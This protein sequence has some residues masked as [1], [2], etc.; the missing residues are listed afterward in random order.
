VRERIERV[1]APKS[2]P[3]FSPRWSDAHLG[4]SESQDPARR[5]RRK[6]REAE[7]HRSG[8]HVD[9]L[10]ALHE[11]FQPLPSLPEEGLEGE[12]P[13]RWIG[14]DEEAAAGAKPSPPWG[15]EQ[16]VHAGRCARLGRRTGQDQ[17]PP[18][19]DRIQ[20]PCS[21]SEFVER[22]STAVHN[23]GEGG[24]RVLRREMERSVDLVRGESLPELVE[25][26]RRP[27]GPKSGAGLI[28]PGLPEFLVRRLELATGQ[29]HS[30]RVATAPARGCQETAS[31][32]AEPL[33][34]PKHGL[35]A[36]GTHALIPDAGE[37]LCER[38]RTTGLHQ[39]EGGF[40]HGQ[41]IGTR[42]PSQGGHEPQRLV[43]HL[44]MV[45]TQRQHRGL[46][47]ARIQ[48]EPQAEQPPEADKSGFRLRL[49]GEEPGFQLQ[50]RAERAIQREVLG[51][52]D[53][54]R[55]MSARFLAQSA[56][57]ED[58]RERHASVDEQRRRP[59]GHEVAEGI[60]QARLGLLESTESGQGSPPACQGVSRGLHDSRTASLLFGRGVGQ[61][62]LVKALLLEVDI[63]ERGEE[64]D[65]MMVRVRIRH[66]LEGSLE[67]PCSGAQVAEPL[68]G[69]GQVPEKA[70]VRRQTGN[71]LGGLEVAQTFP[72]S[73]L[74]HL[75]PAEECQRAPLALAILLGAGEVYGPL[76][77]LGSLA[78]GADFAQHVG[79]THQQAFPVAAGFAKDAPRQ[80]GLGPGLRQI[81]FSGEREGDA[82]AGLGHPQIGSGAFPHG[83]GIRE[84]R[85]SRLGFAPS[86]P[87]LP[88][89]APC[90]GLEGTCAE[91]A[92]ASGHALEGRNL[93]VEIPKLHVGPGFQVPEPDGSEAPVGGIQLDLHT[94]HS[95]EHAARIAP[96]LGH[97]G[98]DHG[99]VE[100]ALAGTGLGIPSS[101][102]AKGFR[103]GLIARDLPRQVGHRLQRILG[104]SRRASS[105]PAT[106]LRGPPQGIGE[107]EPVDPRAVELPSDRVLTRERRLSEA[108]GDSVEMDEL[109]RTGIRGRLG[110]RCED[111]H[112]RPEEPR[113]DRADSRRHGRSLS[114]QEG[115][116]GLISSPPMHGDL[117]NGLEV[118]AAPG[119]FEPCVE[120]RL[121]AEV[122]VAL[123]VP[124]LLSYEVP[125]ALARTIEPGM[126]VR[127]PVGSRVATAFVVSVAERAVDPASLRPIQAVADASPLLSPR[128]LE[129]GIWMARRY[130]C[131][132]GEALEAVVPAAVRQGRSA[133]ETQLVELVDRARAECALQTLE[134]RGEGAARQRVLRLLLE[135]SGEPWLQAE[136]RRAARVS[137]SPLRTLARQGLLRMRR[138]AAESDPFRD[139]M[140]DRRP[141]P[142][143]L[144]EQEAA[145]AALAPQVQAGGFHAALLLGV[146]G[147]GKTEVYLR[148][149]EIVLAAGR[150]AILLVPEIA[151]TPQ[152][153]E[154]LLGRIPRVAVLHSGL[155]EGERARRWHELRS[156]EVRVAVGP[157]S[158]LFAPVAGLGLIILDEEHETTFKQQQSPRYHA[159]DVALERARLEGAVLVLGTATPSLEAQALVVSGRLVCHR[160][161]RRTNGRPMPEVA[162]VDMRH[163]KPVGAAAFFSAPLLSAME[164]TLAAGEQV[165]LFLNRRGFSTTVLC[166]LCG[167]S[168]A[169]PRCAIQ[170]TH[171][172]ST[173]R[174]L[175]HYCAHEIGAPACCPECRHPGLRYGGF[176]TERVAEAAARL[177][178]SHRVGRMDAESLRR[179]GAAARSYRAV[180]E[181]RVDIVVG[182]QVLAK[183]I[184]IP[185]ITL[186]G[187][188]SA[189]TSLLIPDFRSAER[190]F[191]LLCQ[192]AGRAGRSDRPGRVVVQTCQ[193]G[194]YAIRAAARHDVEGFW[195]E[196]SAHRRAQGYPPF[197]HLVRIVVQSP[198]AKV[199]AEEA[200]RVREALDREPGVGSGLAT[201]LGP[202]PCPIPRIL[203]ESRHHILIRTACEAGLDRLMPSLPRRAR[204]GARLLLDRDP[205]ALM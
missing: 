73:P 109:G 167:W 36:R 146:T 150:G 23:Q 59:V 39:V 17:G 1:Q 26:R 123:P 193:P 43:G 164:S 132:P 152:T 192:V 31:G 127:V 124:G 76:R 84:G 198:D 64:A 180:R 134:A 107:E 69:D 88:D 131:S 37:A 67:T 139:V 74:E 161:G 155:S 99:I 170:L 80:K 130:G 25:R 176:G 72:E 78:H 120:T 117:G 166:R 126:R 5:P 137:I 156:G 55:R 27:S 182:T 121:V 91:F 71:G 187:V 98:G 89:P 169:C 40:R 20:D 147:S 157:R 57:L 68:R 194:H 168:A 114:R 172:R 18:I 65:A 116:R 61:D 53:G 144:P 103:Q 92:G 85:P 197:G 46:I 171:Y 10:L 21:G 165:L 196:E 8:G 177:F 203:G 106:G 153:L 178:P 49:G 112:C 82:G 2:R 191:Q 70:G 93:G 42:P 56:P 66:G 35:S 105:G 28:D 185:G 151:L 16:I 79:E 101:P 175:C 44:T 52:L 128:T 154:R 14:C 38:D 97:V 87:T 110:H 34:R 51:Q 115:P 15:H 86:Q 62:G 3:P 162:V 29:D 204:R 90:V 96:S 138:T 163:Q 184:D 205:V 11:T 48:I 189:D 41:R 111:E 118:S 60:A 54:F 4:I 158:A 148:L 143:L 104:A 186:V 12:G 141:P 149:L 136:L 75:D 32:H 174:L 133:Q 188:I 7:G 50:S 94:G 30:V 81:P 195:R 58:V 183:G 108:S 190:T 200:Q 33:P 13:E 119:L 102:G 24:L 63:A 179:R 199:A 201:V 145:V 9:D 77:H 6:I 122:A 19:R 159:R 125:A 129:L 140:P 142:E 135:D 83:H 47:Q 160:L 95:V 181:G 113:E 22:R 45:V 173:D 202:A 100:P